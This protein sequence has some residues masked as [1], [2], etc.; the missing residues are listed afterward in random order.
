MEETFRQELEG[1]SFCA[2]W[3]L[4]GIMLE[5]ECGGKST[6][7]NIW[8][9]S[10]DATVV[11]GSSG[12]LKL[13]TVVRTLVIIYKYIESGDLAKI[14]WAPISDQKKE[15]QK[16]VNTE[17]MVFVVIIYNDVMLVIPVVG[18]VNGNPS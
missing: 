9:K 4:D 15:L 11:P 18:G 7:G 14:V 5:Q 2:T 16:R 3:T 1:D 6:S 12:E 10:G 13:R 17:I 8:M